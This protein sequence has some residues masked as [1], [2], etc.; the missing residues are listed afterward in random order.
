[1]D[2]FQDCTIITVAHRVISIAHYDQIIVM[3][4]GEIV[5][6]GIPFDLLT[7]NKNDT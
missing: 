6:K 2:L 1:M 3:D 4:K 5:E 7:K